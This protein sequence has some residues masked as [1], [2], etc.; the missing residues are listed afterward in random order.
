M[1]IQRTTHSATWKNG[2][3]WVAACTATQLTP[4]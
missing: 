4:A 2:N 1:T 3:T